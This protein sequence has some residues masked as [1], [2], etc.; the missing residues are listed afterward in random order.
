MLSIPLCALLQDRTGCSTDM[1][2]VVIQD[3]EKTDDRLKSEK[4]RLYGI[5]FQKGGG[6]GGQQCAHQT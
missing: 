4:V 3:G 2:D 5:P 6:Q 1:A